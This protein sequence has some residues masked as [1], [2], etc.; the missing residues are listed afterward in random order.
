VTNREESLRLIARAVDEAGDDQLHGRWL[1]TDPDFDVIRV[2][3]PDEW[4]L[5]TRIA[6]GGSP[7]PSRLPTSPWAWYW[8]RMRLANLELLL[9][10]AAP[11]AITVLLGLAFDTAVPEI[12]LAVLL[13]L[14]L[15]TWPV[16][17]WRRA[18]YLSRVVRG[19]AVHVLLNRRHIREEESADH[20]AQARIARDVP[21]Q[22]RYAELLWREA[23]VLGDPRAR[24][25]WRRLDEEAR[26]EAA[27]SEEQ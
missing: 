17:R 20:A 3:A 12:V 23:D 21:D 2:Q 11:V 18:R 10:A 16:S 8:W 9:L 24:H 26:R 19:E 22:R 5:A 25:E 6:M 14:G 15:A 4:S 13:L 27:Q 1:L 7:R